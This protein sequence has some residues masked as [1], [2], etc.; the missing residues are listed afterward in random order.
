MSDR[1]DPTF[2]MASGPPEARWRVPAVLT[3]FAV[4]LI[5]VF[6]FGVWPFNGGST[7]VAAIC[8]LGAAAAIADRP[9]GDPLSGS[10]WGKGLVFGGLALGVLTL[11]GLNQAI[12]AEILFWLTTG[13]VCVG[14]VLIARARYGHGPAG[15]RNHDTF[16]TP[17]LSRGAVAWVAAVVLTGFYVLLYWFP[18]TLEGLIRTM[19]P[20][21]YVMRGQAADQWFMYGTLYSLAVLVMGIRALY[22]YRH[23]RY[24]KWRTVSVILA[25]GV[26]AYIIPQM[27]VLFNEPEFY[28]SYFWPLKPE[29]LWPG[30]FGNGWIWNHPGRL[31]R[32]MVIWGAVVAIVGVPVLTYFF[33]KRWYCS[34]VC[35]CGCLAETAGD[36]YRH[37]ADSS[38]RSW[39]IERWMI[40]GVLVIVT[41][42]TVL[43]WANS[44]M[45][46]GLLGSF[47]GSY[48]RVYG[49][50]FGSVWAGVIGV[51]FYPLMGARVWCRY[52]CPQ[53]AI[54]GILQRFYS[55]F[56]I[57]TN[58]GQCI[59]CGNCTTYCEM[60]IDVRW[61]AQRGQNIIR[62]SCV[63][64]GMCASVCPRG[65][66]KLENSSRDGRYNGPVLI[67]SDEVDVLEEDWAASVS[68]K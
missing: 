64:C 9:T 1:L 62:A 50:L 37:L 32:F 53:A 30:D 36:P 21:S 26:L 40:H 11:I 56:R 3:A 14:T 54:L 58:G 49:F 29:Y 6:V 23:D 8:L 20:L 42:G 10:R 34:W 61:Y 65:V 13:A 68:W 41:V 39:Q 33:G 46:G 4:L 57:T 2:A 55:R 60:G 51:G 24:Q 16:F 67:T 38:V 35:G 48:A 27:L 47:S 25:Q 7:L 12:P 17:M 15:I 31:G 63:G 5:L 45:E 66:L 44:A 59:S 52:G 28:F 22:R 18:G 19:D 43:L